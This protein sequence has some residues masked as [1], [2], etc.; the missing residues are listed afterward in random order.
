MKQTLLTIFILC[1]SL[2]HFL[3]EASAQKP[4]QAVL[5]IV[6]DNTSNEPLPGAN[7]VLLGSDPLIGTITDENGKFRLDNIEVGYVSIAVTYVGY[8]TVELTNME[9]WS[10]KELVLEIFMDELT[11]TGEEVEIKAR[12][13]KTGSINRMTSVSARTFTVDETRR[14]AGT[15]NDVARMASNYAGIQ[16]A[17]DSRNDIIIR[18]NSPSGLQWRIE[19]LEVPNPNHFAS[20]GTTGGPVN[21]INNNQLNNSDFLTAAFPGEFGNATAGVFDLKLRNGNP[22]NYEFV[23]QL[24]FNGFELDAEGP[25]SRKAGSSFTAAYRYSTMGIFK[26]IGVTFGTGTAVPEYQDLSFKVNFPTKKAGTFSVYGMGGVSSIEFLDSERDT[27]QVDFYAGEGYD[28]RSGSSLAV[29]G[30]SHVINFGRQAFIKTSISYNYSDYYANQDSINPVNQDIVPIYRSDFKEHRL[31][32]TSFIKKRVN[33]K[34]NF[35][36]GV[37]ATLY[38]NDLRDSI[39]RRDINQFADGVNYKGSAWLIQPYLTWQFKFTENLIL[40]TGVHAQFYTFNSTYSVEPR[41]GLKWQ[42]SPASAFSFGYGLHS[43]LLPAL[44][45]NQESL[46]SDGTYRKFNEDLSMLKSHHFV[47]GYDLTINNYL[48]F[49]TEA[50]YQSIYNAAVNAHESDAYSILNQGAQFYFYS[51]D[52]LKSTGTGQN[53]G[54]EFTIEHF[55][56]RGM[57][58]LGTVSL[59]QSH[60]EGSDMV[61]RNTA[62]NSN[63]VINGLFGKDF[64]L[65]KNS[66]NPKL[67]KVQR[68][69]GFDIKLSYAGGR[70]YTPINE[71]KSQDQG[72]PVYYYDQA[73]EEKF[74]NYF[75]TDFKIYFRMNMKKLDAEIA[76][77]IQNVF[78]TQNIY[79][80]NF[81]SATGEVYYNYQL[82]M[83]IIPQ[84]VINF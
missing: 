47:L 77:D 5:G 1:L 70:R 65:H 27:S 26:L 51:P 80:Q 21:M 78:N 31:N 13:D 72:Q 76:I 64:Q 14:Y 7:V 71:Q 56:N 24:G 4:F 46:Q 15:R 61:S 29:V 41:L 79:S 75:R 50:Y 22:D 28:L 82:G 58:F 18:G 16:T 69:I 33:Q 53:Y 55:L 11:I 59:F 19:G 6:K 35:Q 74:P 2:F 40:N 10:G 67:T 9:L 34:N 73:W 23:G 37:I 25:I 84:F 42:A 30:V 63:F 57:Y 32:I 49:K 83:L 17:S 66:T 36:T 68:F 48:R 81:N 43:Q 60:Y 52:T 12:I 44:V 8:Q 3:E 62:Y 20:F 38:M 39:L 45:Y 54:V